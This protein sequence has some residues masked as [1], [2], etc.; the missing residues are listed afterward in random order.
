MHH[1]VISVK[2]QLDQIVDGLRD[3]RILDLLRQNPSKMG[4]LFT[5]EKRCITADILIALF[6][7]SL[8]PCGHNDREAEEAVIVYWTEFIQK[9]EGI[10]CL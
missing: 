10:C 1:T 3:A 8:S 5:S 7:P 4:E 6:E 9:V 2:A